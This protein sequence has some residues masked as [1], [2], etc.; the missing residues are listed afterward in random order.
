MDGTESQPKQHE[1]IDASETAAMGADGKQGAESSLSAP[2]APFL[3]VVRT[4]DGEDV[5]D[6]FGQD[7]L[8][9][10]M[11]LGRIDTLLE[12]LKLDA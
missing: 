6:Q 11:L 8:K 9:Y 5:D 7:A 2:S 10:Q 3:G 4:L 1:F 12:N